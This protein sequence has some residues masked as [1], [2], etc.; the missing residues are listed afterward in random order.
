MSARSKFSFTISDF[1]ILLGKSPV[2]LRQWERKGLIRFPRVGN[3][4]RLSTGQARVLARYA[5][6]LGRITED[7]LLLVEAAITLL[8]LMENEDRNPRSARSR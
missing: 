3:D 8:E 7:R 2:T 4:R 6:T 1:G 5:R